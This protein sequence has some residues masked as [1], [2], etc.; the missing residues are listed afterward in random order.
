MKDTYHDIERYKLDE[1]R[2]KV[3]EV[4]NNTATI[5]WNN[6]YRMWIIGYFPTNQPNESNHAIYETVSI[7]G[8]DLDNFISNLQSPKG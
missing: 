6:K 2:I 8:I 3:C 7:C 5:G 4:L 1:Y